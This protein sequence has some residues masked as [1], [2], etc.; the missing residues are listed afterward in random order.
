MRLAELVAISR[1]VTE[2]RARGAKIAALAGLLARLVPEEVPLGV[3]YLTGATAQGKLGIGYASVERTRATPPAPSP[4]L[5]LVAVDR[6]LGGLVGLAGAGSAGERQRLLHELFAA[7]TAD[8]QEFLRR[9]LV[10][11]LRQGAL[12]G[13]M[14]EAIA[15]AA[16]VSLAGVRRAL[17]LSGD[18]GAVAAAAFSGGEASLASF[19]LELFRPVLPMLADTAGDVE[20]AV[21]ALGEAQLEHKL[22]GA[23]IQVHRAGELERV[24]SRAGNEVTAAVPEVVEAALALPAT[25][26]V[27]DG[28]AIALRPDGSP[29]PFQVTMQRFGRLPRAG[30]TQEL[31]LSPFFFDLLRESETDLLDAPLAERARALA[32]LLPASRRVPTLVTRD[33]AAGIA[34]YDAAL[35]HGHEGVVAK[36][37]D[38]PYE[39]GRR[40]KNWLKLKPAHT[41]D[42]VVLAAEWGSGRRQGYLSNLHLGAR[43]PTNG[44]YVMLGKTFKGMTDAMLAWQTEWFLAHEIGRDA[45]TVHVAPE[46]VVEIAF[47]TVQAS[48][49][50]PGGVALRFAR[51]KR[52]REDKPAA[53]ADTI[54]A[55]RQIFAR[56]HRLT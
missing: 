41:L 12:E 11:E 56:A 25:S 50:Y 48:P 3:A 31:R 51:V 30:E 5:E 36:S 2:T 10:G 1:G 6:A 46:L 32:A 18:L 42:L 45:Y 29:L 8:E 54:D 7:A 53:Q 28:E 55:V 22:D 9:L 26:F 17:M 20:E 21:A 39:A 13:V 34:F 35:A 4:T 47:D 23:R 38:S 33:P 49:H 19:K 44:G 27:L 15:K 24:F 40:G 16:K 43:D 14:S 52:Y 37:T